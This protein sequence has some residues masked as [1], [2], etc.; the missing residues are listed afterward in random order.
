MH[1]STSNT[2]NCHWSRRRPEFPI[3]H[4]IARISKLLGPYKIFFDAP[5]TNEPII[6]T[7]TSSFVICTT[8]PGATE[9]LLAYNGTCAFFIVVHVTSSISEFIRRGEE[10]CTR[11]G[12]SIVKISIEI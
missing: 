1:L 6:Y 12:E 3:L 9:G 7:D 5:R 4:Q 10:G 11:G 2:T 8:G